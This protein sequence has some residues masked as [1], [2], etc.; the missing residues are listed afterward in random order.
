MREVENL[1]E[2]WICLI[3]NRKRMIVVWLAVVLAYTVPPVRD[4]GRG[5][6]LPLQEGVPVYGPYHGSF[7][8]SGLGLKKPFPQRDAPIGPTSPW[9]LHC[10][11]KSDGQFPSYTLL[12]GFGEPSAPAG[13]QRYLAILGGRP[14]LWTGEDSV[15]APGPLEPGRWHF[16]A[17]TFDGFTARLYLEGKEAV[18]KAVRLGASTAVMHLAPQPLPWPQGEHFNGKIA[19]FTLTARALANDEIR[20]LLTRVIP[21]DVLPFEAGSKAWTVSTSGVLGLKAPQNP[22]TL[23]KSKAPPSKPSAKPL[24]PRSTVLVPRGANTWTLG[25][26][27][28]LAEAPKISAGGEALS[29][30]GFNSDGWLE[31]VV[32]G[33]VLTTFVERGIYPDPDYAL[34]NLAIPETLNKQDYWY[35]IEFTPPASAAGSRLSLTFEGINYAAEVWL[36]GKRLGRIKGAFLRGIFDVTGIAA[37]GS[38]NALAVLVSPPP[39]PGIPHEQ[40][41]KAGAGLNGGMLCLDG[42]T[43]ICTEGWDWLPAVRDRNTGIWQEVILTATGTVRIG[44]VQVVTALPLPATNRADVRL[45]VPLTNDSMATVPGVLE[46]SFEGVKI[47]KKLTLQPGRTTV[48]MLPSEFPQLAVVNPRLWWPNGY[49][50]PDLYHLRIAFTGAKGRSDVRNLRFGMREITYELS[51]L[52]NTGRLR[53]VE[54]APTVARAKREH[55]VDIRHEAA[56]ETAVGYTASFMPGAQSSASVRPLADLRASPFLVIRVNGVRIACKGGNWGLDDSRKRVSRE[57]LEPYVRLH[58]DANFTM[59]RNWCGQSTEET[60]YD[61]CDEY[62]L[63]VWN[64]FWITTQDSNLDPSD[65]ALFLENAHDTLL[66]FRN[67]PSIAL[68]C[69]RNE[70]VPSP[71]INE[72]L[73]ELIRELDGTRYYMPN[74]RLINLAPSGPWN[75]GEPVEFFTTRARG[76]STELGLPSPPTIETFR[77]MMPEP[78]LWPPN[79]TWAYHDWH[80]DGGGRVTPFTESLVW[81]LGA[82]TSLE[83]FVRKAQVLNYV[84]HRA[85]FEGFNAHLWAPNTGRLLWMSQPAWPSMSWQLFSHDYD[86]HASYYG[87]KKACEPIHVQLNLPELKTAV[88]NNTTRR[89]EDLSLT[90]RIVSFD[91]LPVLTREAKLSAPPNATTESVALDLPRDSIPEV[92]FIKLELKDASGTLLSDNFYWHAPAGP[93]FRRLNGLPAADISGSARVVRSG[94]VARIGIDLENHGRSVALMNK[95]T[96]L[97]SVAGQSG[98]VTRVL[99]AYPSDNYVSL[100]PGERRHLEIEVPA[101]AIQGVLQI[102]LEGWNTPLADLPVSGQ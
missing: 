7:I 80:A 29:K 74:S 69:G 20:A 82:P 21:L 33:T 45:T 73:D 86:T 92:V 24:S 58:R 59:I 5:M 51:L 36:N 55:V 61:L 91:G 75:H 76:F 88:V 32:P 72:G 1:D 89:L 101:G 16:V 48:T 52:D 38:L 56:L 71:A 68:W 9:T 60:L 77:A 50:S 64:D 97:Q 3:M 39:H 100:L 102:R 96:L 31:A 47:S 90:T 70:G 67:H 63:L 54:F 95:V 13:Q 44:D 66:R 18:V 14:G 30:P 79:D 62:G 65:T 99:P 35:R 8:P 26:G 11:V 2:D 94:N 46:A 12:A 37:P 43:F 53:R 93:A 57:Q 41:I 40:S 83:D 25:D 17:A 15:L 78:D 34:N 23:P 27:W 19:D 4:T 28:R 6:P 49:G 42:P 85:M 98:N 81:Q 10:W 22:A 84:D 87:V